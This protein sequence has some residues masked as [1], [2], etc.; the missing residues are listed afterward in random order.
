V[1]CAAVAVRDH[2]DRRAGAM[3]GAL[4][5]GAKRMPACYLSQSLASVGGGGGSLPPTSPDD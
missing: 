2:G 3:R 5:R 4:R 1:P